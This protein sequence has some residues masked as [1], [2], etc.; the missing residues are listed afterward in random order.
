MELLQAEK[1]YLF[2]LKKGYEG[3]SLFDS[4]TN[5][6]KRE[7][8]I[9]NDLL[10]EINNN[11]F[12]IDTLIILHNKVYLFEVKNYT[13]DYYYQS[14]KLF[15]KPNFEIINPLHQLGRS[16]SLLR[17][18][19][20]SAG[21]TPEI[22]S[23]IVFINPSF[24]LYQAPLDKPIIFPPQISRFIETLNGSSS[25]LTKRDKLLA[26][27]ILEMNKEVS[28]FKKLPTYDYQQLSK[29][30]FCHECHSSSI[31]IHNRTCSCDICGTKESVTIAVLR[32]IQEFKILFP[33]EKVTTTIISDWCG[34]KVSP[35]T[36]SRILKSNFQKR[37]ERRWTYYE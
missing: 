3:E 26:E 5:T 11:T 29:G 18:L 6:V 28:P 35:K 30:I 27:K 2:N 22:N 1:Q 13:G 37:G 31:T 24:M 9:L 36:I 33:Q 25:T 16:E 15:R 23:S 12:Q 19:L 32:N 8:L 21:F 4:F 14:E 17:Q 7:C 10:F 34:M 20:L